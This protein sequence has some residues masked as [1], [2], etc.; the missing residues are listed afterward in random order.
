M[1]GPSLQMLGTQ[2][3][4]EVILEKHSEGWHCRAHIQVF[5]LGCGSAWSQVKDPNPHL[6][7]LGISVTQNSSKKYCRQEK[8]QNP[9]FLLLLWLF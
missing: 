5:T 8:N 4:M 7:V 6:C 3:Q 1:A 2:E 9:E